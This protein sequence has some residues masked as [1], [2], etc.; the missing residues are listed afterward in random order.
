LIIGAS[1]QA[2]FYRRIG[3]GAI[4]VARPASDR[5]A[6]KPTAGSS[7]EYGARGGAPEGKRNGNYGHGAR[8]KATVELWRFIKSLR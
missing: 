2:E 8:T 5:K 6:I 1:E 4:T 3:R 7:A